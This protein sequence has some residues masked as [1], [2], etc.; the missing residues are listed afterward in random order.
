MTSAAERTEAIVIGGGVVGCAVLRELAVHGIEG[1]LV[2]AQA[3]LGEGAS[4]AN[5]AILH[6]GFDAKPGTVEATLLR[7]AAELWPPLLDALAVPFLRCG[8]L[9]IARTPDEAGRLADVAALASEHGVRT[10]VL[11]GRALREVAPYITP[12]A[13]AAL[14]IP[15]EGIVDPFWLTRSYAEAAIALGA[16]VRTHARVTSLEVGTD[17]VVVG[18]DDGRTLEAHHAFD[19]AGLWSDD[20]ARLAGD[21]SFSLTPRKGQF[22]VSERTFDVDR[23][24]LPIP[25]PLGK[26]MLVTPIVFGG[27]LL[28]PTAEDGTDKSDRSTNRAGREAIL[29]A[30][31]ALV[32]DVA[33][34]DPIRAFAGVRAVSSTGDFIIR[35]SAA[36]DRLT[37]VAGIRSTGI[38][39]SPAIAEAVV[40]LA[41]TA[42]GWMARGSRRQAAPLGTDFGSLAGS[43]VCVCRS[44]SGSEVEA[45]LDGPVPV[46][47]TDALK[48]RSGVG[49][50]DCQGNRCLAEAI[51]RVA[52]ARGVDPAAVEKG[53]DGS[54]HVMKPAAVPD[55]VAPDGE[56]QTDAPHE[57]LVDVAIVGGGLAGI[58]AALATVGAG[59]RV[60]VADRGQSP[61]GAFANMPDRLTEVER[62]GLQT[63][64]GRV[65]TG[66]IVWWSAATVVGLVPVDGGW[67]LDVQTARGASTITARTVVLATGGYVTP[68]EHLSIDG[69]RPSGVTTADFVGD[70]LARGWLPATRVVVVGDGRLADGIVSRLR[71]AGMEVVERLMT[72]RGSGDADGIGIDAIRGDSRLE[73]V[74]VGDRW[75]DADGLVLAHALRPASFLLRGLGIGDDRPGIPMPVDERGALP[76]AGLWAAGTCVDPAVDHEHSL[77]SGTA[78]GD[79]IV[80]TV[81]SGPVVSEA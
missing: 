78:V 74:R 37:I 40:A 27:L 17:R 46:T 63:L 41:T 51:A 43:I 48:R 80:A 52:A 75:I 72:R 16:Q 53:A 19:C 65:E 32:P 3:D 18:L 21:A 13:S 36:G 6:T 60:V 24:V 20:V 44:V 26:G 9:M 42:R 58:G 39:A 4:K 76:L 73:A 38:S 31:S 66:E 79:A 8:A 29:R 55:A 64:A 1:V 22:L 56:E 25:G 61:G 23:I 2:E 67:Q 54:W 45:A 68:R 11:D 33:R 15:D 57:L 47:T 71:T 81:G 62:S 77:E 14:S 50:G 30:C 35:P 59:L 69:P 28:G 5:S 70:A 10:E 7:R 49:F 12:Q 34:M